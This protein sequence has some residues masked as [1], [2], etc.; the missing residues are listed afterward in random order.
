MSPI[1]MCSRCGEVYEGCRHFQCAMINLTPAHA[2]RVRA[3]YRIGQQFNPDH[4]TTS[5]LDEGFVP[6]RPQP[7][8][9]PDLPSR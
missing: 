3:R 6:E 7:R 5:Y 8:R 2:D 9:P 1:A 4:D